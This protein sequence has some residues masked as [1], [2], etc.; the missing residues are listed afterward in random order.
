MKWHE[1]RGF[2]PDH[3]LR[4]YDVV[5]HTPN[6]MYVLEKLDVSLTFGS[7][8]EGVSGVVVT[9]GR[10]A[11]MK[12]SSSEPMIRQRFAAAHALG[13]LLI[14]DVSMGHEDIF[15]PGL[16]TSVMEREANVFAANLLMPEWMVRPAVDQMGADLTALAKRFVVSEDAMELRLRALY[17]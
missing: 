6:V 11:F 4:Y 8:E 10:N 1:A 16:P 17:R 15:T 13:H 9:V 2:T 12:I 7:T 14:H 5:N 3:I